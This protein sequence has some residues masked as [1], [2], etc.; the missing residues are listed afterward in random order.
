MS[1]PLKIMVI[2]DVQAKE[3]VRLDHLKWAGRCAADKRP[4]DVRRG[5]DGMRRHVEASSRD[6]GVG[7]DKND[8]LIKRA[9]SHQWSVD[10][11]ADD[12]IAGDLISALRKLG[13]E[14][15][16]IRQDDS[17][18]WYVVPYDHRGE[19]DNWLE[20]G[21]SEAPYYAVRLDNPELLY[22]KNYCIGRVKF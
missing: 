15:F 16:C 9:I 7:M 4:D 21:D 8:K 13:N 6:W 19:F 2:P 17:C 14:L 18:H 5:L 10:A 1:K 12:K 3:G 22:F 11:D 20:S